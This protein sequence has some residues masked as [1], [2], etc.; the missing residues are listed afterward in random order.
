[1]KK[2]VKRIACLALSMTMAGA[3]LA[4]CGSNK[5]DTETAEKKTYKIGICQL[6]QHE[7]LDAATQGFKDALTEKLGDK[8]TFDEQNASGEATNCTTI[9][10]KFVS[11][12]VDLIL[13][14]AT[15][16][17]TA[18]SQATA[19]IPIVAT[20]ITDYATALDIKDWTGKTGFNVT[21]TSDLAPLEEQANM[22]KELVPDAK[23][24]GII[25]CS[26]ENNSKYQATEITKY[27]KELGLEAKEYTFVDTNDVTAV[28]KQAAADCDAIFA[29]TDNTVASNGPAINNVLE[30]AKVPL[31]AGE[32]GICEK[33]G[34]AT[35][36]ID[37]H[38]IGY[39]AGE[40]AYEI[41]VNGKDPADMEIEYA[42]DLTKK[43][44]PERCKALGITV[45]DD[46]KAIEA[47]A[48]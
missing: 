43:Y 33:C 10:S 29:P 18:A 8:V 32:E 1:M 42:K 5:D 48:E 20:S 46:Y 17:L 35:L 13:A 3:C 11:D 27:L 15:G 4:G 14:N 24:V 22:I 45:P 39:K 44:M 40:M 16:A 12:K 6:V 19:D 21:G 23:K 37:Y 41:L 34:I 38:D 30:P 28:T 7:A 36:S 26:A 2:F 31:I 9:C 25:Y 47:A